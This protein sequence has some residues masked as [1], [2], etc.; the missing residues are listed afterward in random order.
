[1]LQSEVP[2]LGMDVIQPHCALWRLAV[3]ATRLP[4]TRNSA[5]M[6]AVR[7]PAF[8]AAEWGA[9]SELSEVG[10]ARIRGV[11]VWV[12]RTNMAMGGVWEERWLRWIPEDRLP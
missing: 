5:T 1:M 2:S 9:I 4:K 8:S 10:W 11:A 6:T 7:Q 12:S 3:Q